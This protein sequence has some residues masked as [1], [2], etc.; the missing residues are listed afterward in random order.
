MMRPENTP[1]ACQVV[2]VVHDNGDE[3][4]NDQERAKHEEGDEVGVGEVHSAI[5]VR[6]CAVVVASWIALHVFPVGA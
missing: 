2:E 6:I 3:Q 4:V 1:V 5:G